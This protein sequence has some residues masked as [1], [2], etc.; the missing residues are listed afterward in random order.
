MLGKAE[1]IFGPLNGAEIVDAYTPLTIRDWVSSPEGSPYGIR[2]SVQQLPV[3]ASFH[4]VAIGGLFFAGQNSMAP[5]ILG[6]VLGSF[7]TVRQMIGQERFAAVYEELSK[8]SK[9]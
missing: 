8:E 9:P 5:G 7:Q 3:A 1:E 6:T 2:R 4:R